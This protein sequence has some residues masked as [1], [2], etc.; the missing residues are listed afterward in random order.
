MKALLVAIGLTLTAAVAPACA[1][2]STLPAF[3]MVIVATD[4]GW[5]AHCDFGCAFRA[6]SFT[7]HDACAAI[8]DSLGL[9]TVAAQPPGASPF[10]FRL[11]HT[12]KGFVAVGRDGTAWLKLSYSCDELPCSARVTETGVF[13][14]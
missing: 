12:P 13:W 6:A 14:R 9:R 10:S 8:A 5:A 3:S 11:E 4:T 2:R 7:C 1:S